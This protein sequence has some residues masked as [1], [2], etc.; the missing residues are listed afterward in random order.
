MALRVAGVVAGVAIPALLGGCLGGGDGGAAGVVN[1][2]PGF[3]GTITTTRHDGAGDD[4]LTAGLGKTGLG[5]AAAPAFANP[6]APTAAELRRNAIFGNYRAMLDISPKGGYGTLY[7]PNI[8]ASGN[9]TLGEGRIAG[10]EYLAYADDGTGR[11]NVTMLV[12]VPASFRPDRPCIVAAASPGS[13]GVY[14]AIGS[15]GEWGLKRGC[16]VAYTDKGTGLGTHDLATDTVNLQDG[17]RAEAATAGTKSNFTA[18]VNATE[19]AD[20][21]TAHPNR[22]AFKHAHSQQNPE[23][24]WGN[25]TLNAVRFA[26]YVL[27]E[28]F[29]ARTSDD[30][31]TVRFEPGNTIVIASSVSHGGA[32][33]IAAAEQDVEGLIDGVAVSE[34]VLQQAANPSLVVRQGSTS[35]AGGGKALL[36]YHTLAN[37]HQPCA[38]LSTRAVGSPGPCRPPAEPRACDQPLCRA[39]GERPAERGH[40]RR[41]GRGIDGHAARCRLLRP[42]PTSCM[43]RITRSASRRPW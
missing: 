21:N 14:G 17:T 35:L 1:V 5:A 11:K 34:P 10:T 32:S 27:N 4:L 40:D 41:A 23:M 3:V 12:Q 6:A 36:D 29:G 2:K 22:V 24:D 31:A 30:R 18:V 19:L 20:F 39:E 15:A 9:D 16:A 13:R 37:L 43:H 28:Q 33:A 42:S 25:D 26:F 7:G 8:D 38:T